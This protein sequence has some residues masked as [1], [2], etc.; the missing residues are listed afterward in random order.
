MKYLT[1]EDQRLRLLAVYACWNFAENCKSDNTHDSNIFL[2]ITVIVEFLRCEYN[3]GALPHII[4]FVKSDDPDEKNAGVGW[5]WSF[6]EQGTN[7]H[8]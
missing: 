7:M 5:L 3:L 1:N 8:N 6:L 2:S 4:R